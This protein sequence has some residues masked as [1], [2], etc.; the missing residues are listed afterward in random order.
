MA[1]TDTYDFSDMTNETE[2]LVLTELERQLNEI[3][4]AEYVESLDGETEADDGEGAICLCNE[5]VV[6]MACAALNTVRPLYHHSLLGGLYTAA[7]IEDPV[8]AGELER[9]VREAIEKVRKNPD[10]D[11]LMV[12]VD[13]DDDEEDDAEYQLSLMINGMAPAPVSNS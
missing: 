3:V 8:F 5:C 9:A 4:A 12:E 1:L 13:E 7:S 2:R 11:E 6:D 10:H